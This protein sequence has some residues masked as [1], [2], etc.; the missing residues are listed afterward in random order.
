VVIRGSGGIH[1]N[2][3]NAEEK[4]EG[5]CENKRQRVQKLL[6]DEYRDKAHILQNHQVFQDLRIQDFYKA[7]LRI[8]L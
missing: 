5:F 1:I 4:E 2:A 6:Q 3:G 8:P 7:Y